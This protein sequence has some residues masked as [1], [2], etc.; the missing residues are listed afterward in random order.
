MKK[1]NRKKKKSSKNKIESKTPDAIV[2]FVE[3]IL[4]FNEQSDIF[5]TPEESPRNIM[6]NLESEESAAQRG[7]GLKILFPEQ[8]LSRLPISLAQLKVGNDSEKLKNE[9][10]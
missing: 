1:L 8:M 10:R 5:Y 2:D 4:D 6:H 3:K 7:Q 9:I